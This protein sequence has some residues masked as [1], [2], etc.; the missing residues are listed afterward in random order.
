VFD[1]NAVME[2]I[3]YAFNLGVLAIF[4]ALVAVLVRD[5]GDAGGG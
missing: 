2:V 4:L 5:R 1:L 3:R